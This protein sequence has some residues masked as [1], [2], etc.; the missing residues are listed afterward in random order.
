[1]GMLLTSPHRTGEHRARPRG[2][3]TAAGGW[4]VDTRTADDPHTKADLLFQVSLSLQLELQFLRHFLAQTPFE[5]WHPSFLNS[6]LL[7]LYRIPQCH[8]LRLPLPMSDYV[9]DAKSVMDNAVRI[10]QQR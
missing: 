2:D 9:T 6:D 5:K 4:Q 8:F 3:L 7:H 1:M 10:I